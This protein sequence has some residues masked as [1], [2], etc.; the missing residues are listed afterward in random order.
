MNMGENERLRERVATL[1][2][3]LREIA[4]GTEPDRI[5]R[6]DLLRDWV[7]GTAIAALAEAAPKE[8]P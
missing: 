4:E 3:A 1:E 5:G 7:H 2:A 6:Y 8:K